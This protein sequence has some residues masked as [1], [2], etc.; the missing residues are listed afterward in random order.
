MQQPASIAGAPAQ[1][2]QGLSPRPEFGGRS[3]GLS[4]ESPP[5]ARWPDIFVEAHTHTQSSTA[6]ADFTLTQ[7]TVCEVGVMITGRDV[8]PED[9]DRCFEITYKQKVVVRDCV[10]ACV[11]ACVL[12]C[13][14]ACMRVCVCACVHACMDNIESR[15]AQC[16]V[17]ICVSVSDCANARLCWCPQPNQE[18][19]MHERN[20]AQFLLQHKPFQAYFQHS[21]REVHNQEQL[22]LQQDQFQHLECEQQQLQQ[23]LDRQ[24]QMGASPEQMQQLQKQALWQMQ[25]LIQQQQQQQQALIQKQDRDLQ[26]MLEMQHRYQQPVSYMRA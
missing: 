17:N 14:C 13:E 25:Q 22:L 2:L 7:H 3:G 10:R 21:L 23:Q 20:Q 26:Y 24:A 11:Q 8:A 19:R 15:L 5:A 1:P 9:G 4:P 16:L 18:E 6:A 12:A